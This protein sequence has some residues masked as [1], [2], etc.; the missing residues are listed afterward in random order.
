MDETIRNASD[1]DS[2]QRRRS[3]AHR[4]S[5]GLLLQVSAVIAM[6]AASFAVA[7]TAGLAQAPGPLSASRYDAIDSIKT[8][9]VDEGAGAAGYRAVRRVCEAVDRSD[10]MLAIV[11]RQCLTALKLLAANDSAQTCQAPRA[12]GRVWGRIRGAMTQLI[13]SDRALNAVLAVEMPAGRCRTLL[14]TSRAALRSGQKERDAARDIQRG[15]IANNRAIVERA[16]KRFASVSR[17]G[18]PRSTST[19]R[20][21]RFRSACAPAQTQTPQAAP[22]APAAP[23]DAA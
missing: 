13:D 2:H 12:C 4:H 20:R 17:E 10:R 22:P 11:R 15:Y 14:R 16:A 19:Q 21:D 23:T 3:A 7:S 8:A 5:H 9:F 18:G 6:T 1:T